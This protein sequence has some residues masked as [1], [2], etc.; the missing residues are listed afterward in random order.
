FGATVHFFLAWLPDVNR[1]L[2]PSAVLNGNSLAHDVPAQRTFIANVNPI[3]GS[4]VALDF[5]QD[6]DFLGVDVGL[7][8]AVAANRYT[9]TRQID[10]AFHAPVNVKRFGAGDFALD[11]QRF[12][13]RRLLLIV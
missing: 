7:D 9:V 11:D 13:D 8:L 6:H 12:T 3:A 1:T 4:D 2:E 5:A 10:G